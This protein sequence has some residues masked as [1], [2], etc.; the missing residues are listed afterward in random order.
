MVWDSLLSFLRTRSVLL[1]AY[2][3]HSLSPSLFLPEFG[4]LSSP[5]FWPQPLMTFSLP[6]LS[7]LF[8]GRCLSF[9][10]AHSLSSVLFFFTSRCSEVSSKEHVKM[11]SD[12]CKLFHSQSTPPP[13]P[14]P[15][16][17][18]THNPSLKQPQ[19]QSLFL[20]FSPSHQPQGHPTPL[21]PLLLCTHWWPS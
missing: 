18:H 14:L 7:L 5:F 9:L 13:P 11:M 15:P 1:N 2:V 10:F 20:P 8:R 6:T 17:S 3:H 21:F 4:P 12:L 19:P 16:P